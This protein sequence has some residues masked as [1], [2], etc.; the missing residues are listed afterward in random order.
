MIMY[1]G[2]IVAELEGESINED[3]IIAKSMNVQ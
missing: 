2:K 3:T 1:E